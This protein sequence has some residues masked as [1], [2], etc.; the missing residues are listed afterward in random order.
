MDNLYT[1]AYEKP[2]WQ[3]S[4]AQTEEEEA[5]EDGSV[6][7]PSHGT[8]TLRQWERVKGVLVGV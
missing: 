1:V 8:Q 3:A 5:F 7:R 4:A 2:T 6:R